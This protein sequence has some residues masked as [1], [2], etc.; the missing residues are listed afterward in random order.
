MKR[1]TSSQKGVHALF[2]ARKEPKTTLGEVIGL[3]SAGVGVTVWAW[4][5]L[6]FIGNV[7][8]VVL[9]DKTA[10]S[11]MMLSVAVPLI[12][13][14][15]TTFAY[16]RARR[17]KIDEGVDEESL[18]LEVEALAGPRNNDHA[19]YQPK[20]GS[21]RSTRAEVA[22]IVEGMIIVLMYAVL[23]RDYD[24]SVYLRQ[25]VEA[26]V[27]VATFILN[28]N[29]FFLVVGVAVASLSFHILSRKKSG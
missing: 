1:N 4:A 26:N 21:A 19:F 9:V 13:A 24:S 25:W 16:S 3:T 11:I 23:L 18:A 7:Q 2:T 14:G 17:G 22:A 29:V 15:S 20:I 28:D 5:L 10:S 6:V 12:A 8:P 27:P